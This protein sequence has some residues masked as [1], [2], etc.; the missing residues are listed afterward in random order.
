[1]AGYALFTASAGLAIAWLL[2]ARQVREGR[3]DG[4]GYELP[5]L[6]TLELA[7]WRSLCWGFGALSL[8]LAWGF[9]GDRAG[10]MEHFKADSI[11]LMSLVTFFF[12]GSLIFF[13]AGG[14]R[15]RRF[16]QLLLIGYTALFFAHYLVNIYWGGHA[17]AGGH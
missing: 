5:A 12:Y 14:L 6:E 2:E 17:L 7:A 15:G 9:F 11:V 8:G 10:F 13:R 1:M 3:L 16:A 4:L